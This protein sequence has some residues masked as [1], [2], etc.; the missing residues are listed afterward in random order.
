MSPQKSSK[1]SPAK[2]GSAHVPV[3]A[4]FGGPPPLSGDYTPLLNHGTDPQTDTAS[5]G[6]LLTS[7]RMSSPGELEPAR[8]YL[9]VQFTNMGMRLKGTGMKVLAGV[10]GRL[11]ASHLTAIMGPSGAGESSHPASNSSKNWAVPT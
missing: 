1:H 3:W 2:Q 10:T 7:P 6:Q 4:S 11:R 8:P 9:D 5:Y